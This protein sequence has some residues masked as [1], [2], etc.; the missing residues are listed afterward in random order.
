MRRLS[1]ALMLLGM[2]AMAHAV[3]P[4]NGLVLNEFDFPSIQIVQFNLSRAIRSQSYL[5]SLSIVPIV[6]MRAAGI[7]APY[8][9]GLGN[10]YQ[11]PVTAVSG[12]EVAWTSNNH[13]THFIDSKA[14]SPTPILRLETKGERI[15][16]RPRRSSI[17]IQWVKTIY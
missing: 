7:I 10:A 15:E 9:T 17:S 14:T 12:K 5:L 13:W 2:A 11:V 4:E 1:S 6:P 8:G 3:V 16:I